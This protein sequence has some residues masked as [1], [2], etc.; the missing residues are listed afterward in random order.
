MSEGKD[1][2]GQSTEGGNSTL[3]EASF[4]GA[5][6]PSAQLLA[7]GVSSPVRKEKHKRGCQCPFKG[8]SVT[9]RKD[10]MGTHAFKFHLPSCFVSDDPSDKWH[11]K[12]DV[13][14]DA[15]IALSKLLRVNGV[16]GLF[17]LL[18]NRWSSVKTRIPP[19]LAGVMGGLCE[20]QGWPIPSTF[21]LSPPNSPAVLLHWRPLLFLVGLLSKKDQ[22]SFKARFSFRKRSPATVT[23]ASASTTRAATGGLEPSSG[24]QVPPVAQASIAV[25]PT[26]VGQ[27]PSSESQVPSIK[28]EAAPIASPAPMQID[29][30]IASPIAGQESSQ[31]DQVPQAKQPNAPIATLHLE[32]APSAT[33]STVVGLESSQNDQVPS[34]NAPIA[35][36][37]PIAISHPGQVQAV[38]RET[39]VGPRMLVSHAPIA[40]RPPG[41][42]NHPNGGQVM[43]GAPFLPAPIATRPPGIPNHPNGGQVMPGAPR[44][45]APIAMPPVGCAP[46]LRP[47]TLTQSSGQ[48]VRPQIAVPDAFDAHFHP[49]RLSACSNGQ[50]LIAPE[51]PVNLIGG[52]KNFCDPETFHMVPPESDPWFVAIGIHPKQAGSYPADAFAFLEQALASRRVSGISEVGLDYDTNSRTWNAQWRLLNKILSLGTLGYVLITHIRGPQSN[53]GLTKR[54]YREAFYQFRLHCSVFQRIHLHCFS[55]DVDTMV[56]WLQAFPNCFVSFSGL[57]ARFSPEQL[58]AVRQCPRQR[59]LLETDSPYLSVRPGKV[60]TPAH[61]GEVARCVAQIRGEPVEVLLRAACENGRRL[62]VGKDLPLEL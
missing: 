31:Q 2:S 45:T 29:A 43:P 19:G 7:G 3:G 49:D 11:L 30:Q 35:A 21:Y 57:V 17:H 39:Q 4:N 54:A 27:E 60:N 25:P 59:L 62:Y 12:H 20:E 61:I 6:D 37:H 34:T 51:V 1:E 26:I 15:L 18:V 44:L 10:K 8:C 46:N 58:S 40:T 22:Q 50:G 47:I 38:S 28:M 14:A 48:P 9:T 56:E 55:G 41:I 33:L 23:P 52:V 32:G 36:S 53:P 16:L 42:P 13:R 24:G 5:S